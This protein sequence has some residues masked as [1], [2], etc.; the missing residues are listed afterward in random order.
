MARL[1]IKGL[2]TID[3][4]S[5]RPFFH[6]R[7][8]GRKVVKALKWWDKKQAQYINVLRVHVTRTAGDI[9]LLIP[10]DGEI[11]LD[12][13]FDDTALFDFIHTKYISRIG[14]AD[15]HTNEILAE[16]IFPSRPGQSVR[17]KQYA[18]LY[19]SVAP[20]GVRA[21]S[22]LYAEDRGSLDLGDYSTTQSFWDVELGNTVIDLN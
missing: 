13:N 22:V 6:E 18:G 14:V 16:Y 9:D 1:T 8:G 15:H 2:Q 20:A 5:G 10:A 17:L 12:V 21:F 3:S 19:S 4:S 7:D 11:E